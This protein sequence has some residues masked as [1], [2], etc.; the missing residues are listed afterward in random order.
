MCREDDIPVHPW[1]ADHEEID[2]LRRFRPRD[3][4]RRPEGAVG[5][6]FQ[7]SERQAVSDMWRE[8]R[9]G[10]DIGKRL[11]GGVDRAELRKNAV[12][13]RG[14]EENFQ[15]LRAI[16]G[17]GGTEGAVGVPFDEAPPYG[18]ND[19]AALSA[20]FGRFSRACSKRKVLECTFDISVFRFT[21][22]AEESY[23]EEFDARN[24]AVGKE[25]RVRQGMFPIPFNDGRARS[26]CLG[27][28]Q[29]CDEGFP[30]MSGGVGKRFC[31]CVVEEAGV[32]LGIRSLGDFLSIGDAV[33]VGVGHPRMG[34]VN[35]F[36]HV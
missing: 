1:I 27:F 26:E 11:R 10:R 14:E 15:G 4:L 34:V 6:S 30:P 18:R 12:R 35:E 5:V 17:G 13:V 16:D 19:E 32:F 7:E 23:F 31:R 21:A 28:P 9:M 22:A 25:E 3:R 8:P 33:A 36:L 2:E 20:P 29:A 24:I